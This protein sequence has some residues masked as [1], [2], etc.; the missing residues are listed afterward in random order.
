MFTET[1]G[2]RKAIGDVDVGTTTDFNPFHLVLP[3]HD[4][5]RTQSAPMVLTGVA[6]LMRFL[7]ATPEAGMI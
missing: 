7:S 4:L 5:S 1:K 6:S 2:S 3:N